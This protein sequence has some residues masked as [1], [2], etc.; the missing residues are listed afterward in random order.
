[1]RA[2]ATA[3][4]LLACGVASAYNLMGVRW[5]DGA[6]PV[7]YAVNQT[8]S[9]DVSDAAALEAI[10]MGFNAW[11]V[12]PCS[13]MEWRDGGRT[14]NTSW[15]RDDGE[16][17]VTW[18]ESGWGDSGGAL[19]ITMNNWGGGNRLSDTDIKFN[20]VNHSWAHFAADPGNDGR[21]D[22][23][24]VA[25]H[26]IGHALGLD[27]TGVRGST[28]WPSVTSGDIDSRTLGPDDIAGA[29]A[30]YDTGEPVPDPDDLPPPS[31]GNADFGEDCTS[32]PCGSDLVCVT[33]GVS[34][35]CSRMCEGE[36]A[37]GYHC[38]R[39]ADGRAACARGPDPDLGRAEFGQACGET[40]CRSGLTCVRDLA[41]A[42]CTHACADGCPN[43]FACARTDD[44]RSICARAVDES[45]LPRGG[46]ACAA[47]RCAEGLVCIRHGDAPTCATTCD[48]GTCPDGQ[49]CVDAVPSGRVCVQRG[50]PPR[51][52]TDPRPGDPVP[53]EPADPNLPQ[54]G[55]ACVVDGGPACNR[56]LVCTGTAVEGDVVVEPGYCTM[57]CNTGRCCPP[58]WGCQAGIRGGRCVPFEADEDTLLCEKPAAV[59]EPEAAARGE[60]CRSV[61]GA[62]APWLAAVWLL[63]GVRRGRS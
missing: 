58:G 32:E 2:L 37:S 23:A 44:G 30:I 6:I 62:P 25:T 36:C 31:A 14:S 48:E 20:G 27:H 34:R 12:L 60:G 21:T 35:Y 55:Q 13:Y 63:L 51:P 40:S 18:R 1:M 52:G 17:A 41:S 47:G 8:L 49:A 3:S 42:Y 61:P 50:A 53:G 26:E 59:P 15:G 38:A 5:D 45:E 16:N 54:M 19:A 10:Q 33:D 29:C 39:L 56:G 43:G 22:I 11:N 46:E 9:G 24:S 7:P 57:A 28:M 4:A